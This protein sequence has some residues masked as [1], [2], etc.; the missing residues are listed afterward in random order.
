MLHL[1]WGL[2]LG[3]GEIPTGIRSANVFPSRKEAVVA[4]TAS[5]ADFPEPRAG[6]ADWRPDE[7]NSQGQDPHPQAVA[8]RNWLGAEAPSARVLKFIDSQRLTGLLA[9]HFT[10]EETETV[11]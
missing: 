5:R 6:D 10:G 1:P 2:T 11:R 9:P 4:S 8:G 3:R 7:D